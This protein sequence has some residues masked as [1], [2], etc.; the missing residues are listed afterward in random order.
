MGVLSAILLIGSSWPVRRSIVQFDS[1]ER[2]FLVST[3]ETDGQIHPDANGMVD[4]PAR[5]H[6][7]LD[8]PVSLIMDAEQP[9]RLAIQELDLQETQSILAGWQTSAEASLD[10]SGISVHPAGSI[11]QRLAD[12]QTV[13]FVWL[14]SGEQQSVGSGTLWLYLLFAPP[15]D[16]TVVRI[17]V[18]ARPISLDVSSFFG[19][20]YQ[21]LQI[22][23]VFGL[24]AGS[25]IMVV[26]GRFRSRSNP[27]VFLLDKP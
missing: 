17:L 3:G 4:L 7:T 26:V 22:V 11:F 5:Y 8:S 18:L 12:R 10:F 23:A 6:I 27:R 13:D 25:L 9:F 19:F 2:G 15:Q 21:N 16:G 20:H 24:L 14:L 1:A